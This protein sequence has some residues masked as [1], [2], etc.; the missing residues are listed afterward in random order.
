[1]PF[2]AAPTPKRQTVSTL[3]AGI[4][5]RALAAE[6]PGPAR[7]PRSLQWLACSM[8]QAWAEPLHPDCFGGSAGFSPASRL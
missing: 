7:L 6:P 2:P 3:E 8:Q 1:M 5:A 4:Q